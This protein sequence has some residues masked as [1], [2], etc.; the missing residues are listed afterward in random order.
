M[1]GIMMI[2]KIMIWLYFE[3]DMS[4]PHIASDMPGVERASETPGVSQ[5]ISRE[6]GEIE[7]INP[8]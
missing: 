8:R 7:I 2:W 1:L 6:D 4:H 5:G 3:D